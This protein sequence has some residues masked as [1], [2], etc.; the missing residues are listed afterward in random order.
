MIKIYVDTNYHAV[1]HDCEGKKEAQIAA[2]LIPA[3]DILCADLYVNNP[4]LN[5]EEKVKKALATRNSILEHMKNLDYSCEE[6]F[7]DED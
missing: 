1:D 2:E 3:I 5:N 4:L 6:Y 7:E